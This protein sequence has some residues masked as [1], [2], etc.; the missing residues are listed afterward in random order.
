MDIAAQCGLSLLKGIC[1]A[2][3]VPLA[4]GEAPTSRLQAL[5]AEGLSARYAEVPEAQQDG[6]IQR[7]QLAHDSVQ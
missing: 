1:T 3:Q 7:R 4:A 5:C 2:P 6:S